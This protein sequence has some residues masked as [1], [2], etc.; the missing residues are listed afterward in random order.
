MVSIE[1]YRN[2]TAIALKAIRWDASSFSQTFDCWIWA[3]GVGAG[4]ES[5]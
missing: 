5:V 4:D 2:R 1:L 3:F